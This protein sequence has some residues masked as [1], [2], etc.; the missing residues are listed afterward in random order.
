MN[1]FIQKQASFPLPLSDVLDFVFSD[2]E[3]NQANI[4]L[5]TKKHNYVPGNIF[6]LPVEM[7]QLINT[8]TVSSD[9]IQYVVPRMEW[10]IDKEVLTKSDLIVLD[11]IRT[12]NWERPIYF[13]STA[14]SAHYLGLEKYFTLEGM[15]YR[16][17]PQITPL[18]SKE[19]GCTDPIKMYNL[20]TQEF[21][22]I[23]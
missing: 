2:D 4:L 22:K 18:T 12:N 17:I 5:S 21:K 13:V 19:F 15:A 23:L 20:L 11:I 6:V 3:K 7:Q 10:K 14:G 1:M 9:N 8:G 16:L